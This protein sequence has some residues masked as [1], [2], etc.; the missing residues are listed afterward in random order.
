M[1]N[2]TL[3][4]SET[5]DEITPLLGSGL[6]KD[7]KIFESETDITV[8]QLQ[9]H[10]QNDSSVT[11]EID[12]DNDETYKQQNDQIQEQKNSAESEDNPSTKDGKKGGKSASICHTIFYSFIIL[13]KGWKTFI[14]YPVAFA[15][16]GLATLYMTVIGFDNI[17]VGKFLFNLLNKLRIFQ[18][19]VI[20]VKIK[21]RKVSST[22]T[23]SLM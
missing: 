15:G 2:I 12:I 20:L 13:F 8:D 7:K 22:R 10:K 4:T 17:T 21:F 6:V 11:T 16:L 18:M 1:C 5:A 3:P 14:S 19:E 23:F 9:T